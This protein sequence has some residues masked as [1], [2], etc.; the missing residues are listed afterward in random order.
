MWQV[1]YHQQVSG[2]CKIS[3]RFCFPANYNWL[4]WTVF[5]L[6]TNSIWCITVISFWIFHVTRTLWP[7]VLLYT[8]PS[9]SSYLKYSERYLQMSCLVKFWFQQL[10]ECHRGSC[11]KTGKMDAKPDLGG[12]M[13]WISEEFSWC[14][15]VMHFWLGKNGIKTFCCVTSVHVPLLHHCI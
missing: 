6:I 3:A 4:E 13:K 7:G 9:C 5:K 12:M 15:F 11:V 2:F 1:L 8:R 14:T 10:F